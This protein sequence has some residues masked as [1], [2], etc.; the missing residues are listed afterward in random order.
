M[1][2][3]SRDLSFTQSLQPAPTNSKFFKP[4]LAKPGTI[5]PIKTQ[6]LQTQTQTQQTRH[7]HRSNLTNL[8]PTIAP[9]LI[10]IETLNQNPTNAIHTHREEEETHIPTCSHPNG[11]LGLSLLSLFF[12]DS[13]FFL[14]KKFQELLLCQC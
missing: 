12:S 8:E 3:S 9:Q 1:K 11:E 14:K 6:T 7:H 2:S 4:K 10:T 5:V 13:A